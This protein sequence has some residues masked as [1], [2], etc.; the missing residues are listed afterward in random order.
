M[1][2]FQEKIDRFWEKTQE[3]YD[4]IQKKYNGLSYY[5]F[6]APPSEN[7]KLM[8]I[9]LNP[10]GNDSDIK[11]LQQ[12]GNAYTEMKAEW[13]E[14]LRKVF[15]YPNN[16]ELKEI[17]DKCVGT[18]RF[19]FNTGSQSGLEKIK[20]EVVSNG[21]KFANASGDLLN[22][23]VDIIKPEYI[24]A[25]HSDTF[26]HIGKYNKQTFNGKTMIG[27]TKPEGGIPV[28]KIINFSKRMRDKHYNTEEEVKAWTKTIIEFL[29]M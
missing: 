13:F 28:L 11:M 6:Q 22:E 24:I 18:N 27:Y 12:E 1:S 3:L 20:A 17:L 14:T 25:A 7:P 16:P 23:L 21:V 2:T 19:F 4:P 26:N 9:G 15:D 10:G 5:V 8:I 29:N